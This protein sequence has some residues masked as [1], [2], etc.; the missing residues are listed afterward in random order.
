MP[1]KQRER[2]VFEVDASP[3]H[4]RGVFARAD[5]KA[6]KVLW[7][8]PVLLVPVDELEGIV[9]WYVVEWDEDHSALVLGRTSF[10]NH[11]HKPNAELQVD[12]HEQAVSVVAIRAI[13]FGDEIFI[14]YGPDHAAQLDDE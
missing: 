10:L 3:V 6:G 7:T 11:S 13:Q 9:S 12:E 4:G 1:T 5:H 2:F 14:D 8:D